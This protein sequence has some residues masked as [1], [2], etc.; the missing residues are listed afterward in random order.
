M[1]DGSMVKLTSNF[2]FALLSSFQVEFEG[3]RSLLLVGYL[4]L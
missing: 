2:N 1:V 4:W 3:E